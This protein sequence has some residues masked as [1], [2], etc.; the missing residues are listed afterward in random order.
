MMSNPATMMQQWTDMLQGRKSSHEHKSGCHCHERHEHD[1]DCDCHC[2]VR[3]ADAVEYA[4]CGEVR[5]I[6]ITFENDTRR[7]RDVVL[8]LGA[9]ATSGGKELGWQA[10]LSDTNFTLPACGEK[11]VLLTVPVQ[12]GSQD[13]TGGNTEGNRT[14][15]VDT[16]QVAYATLRAEGCRVRPLVI[17]VAVLPN[18]CGG[19]H[20]ECG[21]GCC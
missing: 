1:S 13:P 20:A 8:T 15:Q 7:E 11:T 5:L 2:H 3:C 21:C 19:H 18:H 6:P 16:C 14:N 4:R 9:F 12:C 10:S 17:A